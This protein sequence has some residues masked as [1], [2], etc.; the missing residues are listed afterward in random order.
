MRNRVAGLSVPDPTPVLFLIAAASALLYSMESM[1]WAALLLPGIIL[2][3]AIVYLLSN[4]LAI[5]LGTLMA[6]AAMPR[7][8]LEVGTLKARPE[9]MITGLLCL[10]AVII[11]KRNREPLRWIFPDVLV[12]AFVALNTYSSLFKSPAPSQTIKW[13]IQQSLVVVTYFLVRLLAGNR[14]RWRQAVRIM[15]LIGAAEA[16]YAV[17]CFYSSM[18]FGS[19]FGVEPGQYETIP[20]IYATQYEA[21]ILGSYS[22]ACL[23][24]MLV[25][26]FRERERKFLWGIACTFAG[27]LISLSRAAIGATVLAL[28]VLAVYA[29]ATKLASKAA[30]A[31]VAAAVLAVCL[32]LGPAVWPLYVDRFSTLDVS[33]PSADANTKIRLLMTGEAIAD[34][35]ESPVFGKGTASFQLTFDYSDIGYGDLGVAGS[36]PNTEIRIL[37]DTGAIGLAVFLWFVAVV[38]VRAGKLAWRTANPELAGL[39]LSSVVY[40][41]A[42]QATDASILA[43]PWIHIG[44]IASYLAMQTKP[45]EKPAL[46]SGE[47]AR[48]LS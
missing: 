8:F 1:R 21:N 28:F 47:S 48:E 24:I 10:G 42:F 3:P 39:L 37:H 32:V 29:F 18:F 14:E 13:S 22:G 19:E 4:N 35:L 17:I 36:I 15:L 41:I 12:L 7:F 11:Y 2:L 34:I 20:G 45:G 40:L 25:M 5:A 9:H 27:L 46:F 38:T 43:F 26:Y 23:I 16:V 31:R 6:S 44:L 33:D 30:L